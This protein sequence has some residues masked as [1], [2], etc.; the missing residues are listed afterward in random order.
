MSGLLVD[1]RAFGDRPGVLV[2]VIAADGS[3][4]RG[5]GTTMIVDGDGRIAAGTIGGGALE[6]RVLHRAAAMLAEEGGAE[7]AQFPLGPE[8]GQCCGGR[9]E[10]LF[11]RLP[12]TLD[13]RDG[14]AFVTALEPRVD[15]RLVD[16]GG[17][18]TLLGGSAFNDTRAAVVRGTDG[19]RC[20][21][22]PAHRPRQPLAVF[23]AGHVGRAVVR[24]VAPL[25][26]RVTWIDDRPGQFPVPPEPGVACIT[27]AVPEREVA[28]LAEGAFVLV[29]S[30]THALDYRICRAALLREDIGYIGLIGSDT[31]HARF[32]KW[33]RA[34]GLTDDRIARVSCPI[35]LPGIGGKDP[36][37]IAAS[38][39]ADL[40]MRLERRAA[41]RE[42]DASLR[43]AS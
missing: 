1:I 43:A 6:L 11:E 15:R 19:R 38:V 18:A 13:A 16:R 34:Y 32:V 40:L 17:L 28:A 37:V 7:A 3:T 27:S 12:L 29:M 36:A 4:P 26:F 22:Q 21:V 14:I 23:G 31:K 24:A 35:G 25:P 30:H 39:A 9:V 5:T 41:T 42:P 33:A 20:L 10:L 2:T 8:L